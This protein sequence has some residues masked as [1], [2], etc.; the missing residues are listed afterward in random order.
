MVSWKKGW[1]ETTTIYMSARRFIHFKRKASWKHLQEYTIL[2]SN[3]VE[4]FIYV[5]N[6]IK[7]FL[8]IGGGG[9]AA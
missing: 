6:S 8:Q 5:M 7:L 3:E 9:A 4:I 1:S 2:I